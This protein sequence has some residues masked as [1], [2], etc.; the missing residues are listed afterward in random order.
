[1]KLHD[2]FKLI[3]ANNGRKILVFGFWSLLA[4]LATLLEIANKTK[5][6]NQNFEDKG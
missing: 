3:C 5:F 6:S 4:L 1:M 2:S